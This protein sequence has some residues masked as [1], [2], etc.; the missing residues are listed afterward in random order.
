[1]IPQYLLT[2][3]Q[4]LAEDADINSEDAE[5]VRKGQELLDAALVKTHEIGASHMVGVI[6]SALRKYPG[7]CSAQA[8]ENVVTSLQ[9]LALSCLP[10]PLRRCTLFQT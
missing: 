8:R 6:Y 1:M 3:L 10:F 2:R 4:G 5:V 9:V 7:P